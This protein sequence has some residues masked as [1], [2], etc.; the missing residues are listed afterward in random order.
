MNKRDFNKINA[1]LALVTVV[2]LLVSLY[3]I[4][5]KGSI[6]NKGKVNRE[7]V[8]FGVLFLRASL[9]T[10]FLTILS[11]WYLNFSN[12]NSIE[13]NSEKNESIENIIEEKKDKNNE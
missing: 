10:G 13:E 8:R 2:L 6:L 7:T 1:I 12:S 3:F 4:F 11:R 5:I 9:F